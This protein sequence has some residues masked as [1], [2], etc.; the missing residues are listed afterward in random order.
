MEPAMT[1]SELTAAVIAV[2]HKVIFAMT[3]SAFSSCE[4]GCSHSGAVYVGVGVMVT[5]GVLVFL[6]SLG[7]VAGAD[8][9]ASSPREI[10]VVGSFSVGFGATTDGFGAGSLVLVAAVL[11]S[12]VAFDC[13]TEEVGSAGLDWVVV[14]V[15]DSAAAAAPAREPAAIAVAAKDTATKRDFIDGP[16]SGERVNS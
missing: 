7:F 5:P 2:T 4:D 10:V 1:I 8:S 3:S 9:E 11:D 13:A 12:A 6:G 16:S 14:E 15:A